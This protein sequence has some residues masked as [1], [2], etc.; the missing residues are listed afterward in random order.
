MGSHLSDFEINDEAAREILWQAC[1]AADTA[2]QLATAIRADGVVVQTKTGLRGRYPGL[3]GELAARSFVVRS[4]QRI[5]LTV[6][7]IRSGPGRPA[8]S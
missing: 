1:S 2:E 8:V 7:P 3:K 6:Q 4:L 5:G